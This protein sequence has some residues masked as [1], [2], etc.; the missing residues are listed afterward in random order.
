ML[1]LSTLT[2]SLSVVFLGY[3][4]V[5][6]FFGPSL[7]AIGETY[8]VPLGRLGLIFA[9]F[10][11]AAIPA[12]VFAGQIAE[13]IGRRAA[14]LG[15]MLLMAVGCTLFAAAP[16]FGQRP[17]FAVALATV[18][19]MG[20]AG[21]GVETLSNVVVADDNHPSPG[22][23]LNF[24]HAFFAF[25]A[26]LG[27]VV[28][29]LL[30]R[31]GLSWQ[32]AF[33]LGGGL[34]ALMFLILLPQRV[35][36]N[37]GQPHRRATALE[38]LRS[39]ALWII[40]VLQSCYVGAEVGLGA[41]VS[42]LMERVL[43]AERGLAGLTVSAFWVC[44]G[45]GRIITS[46]LSTR[47]PAVPLIAA[48][49]AAGAVA[50][51]AL[52]LSGSQLGCWIAVSA[53]GFCMSGLFGLFLTVGAQRFH[54]RVGAAFGIL[55]TSVGIGPLVVPPVMGVMA[56]TVGLRPA[57]LVPPALLAVVAVTYVTPGV[58]RILARPE[59]TGGAVA[60]DDGG[61]G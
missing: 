61:T 3:A 56:D 10:S 18:L 49:S 23:A 13:R 27:P 55:L 20:A 41:W 6:F 22:F 51:V 47:L 31:S 42:P 26:V 32:T 9:L 14:L 46:A 17:T 5:L 21:G 38:L 7:T 53:S 24:T 25:G 19:F 34:F 52:A 30:L 28:A 39:P 29:S 50:G 54:D 8:Q 36:R 57:M 33:Y 35:P 60:R 59:A 1:R 11:V 16:S 40:L 44:M 37:Q 48:L 43:G 15:T 45:L 12:V 4:L 2:Y 58:R